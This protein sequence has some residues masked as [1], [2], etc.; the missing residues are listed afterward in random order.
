MGKGHRRSCW[1]CYLRRSKCEGREATCGR[2]A[3]YDTI[4]GW[5]PDDDET[6]E[7]AAN[8]RIVASLAEYTELVENEQ[9]TPLRL[10]KMSCLG[11]RELR[12]SCDEARPSCGRCQQRG[13]ECGYP[14]MKSKRAKPARK[15]KGRPAILLPPRSGPAISSVNDSQT[16]PSSSSF[17]PGSGT[18]P[19]IR[20]PSTTD[21]SVTEWDDEECTDSVANERGAEHS[22]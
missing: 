16:P 17:S 18:L 8:R 3:R 21:T 10:E 12:K 13:L 22:T 9:R 4:C 1:A 7:V 14:E 19:V 2:C 20:G 15:R 11:C 5:P 6:D